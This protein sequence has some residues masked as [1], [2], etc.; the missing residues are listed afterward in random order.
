[1]VIETGA[2]LR[3]RNVSMGSLLFGVKK[4]EKKKEGFWTRTQDAKA[5]IETPPS[6]FLPRLEVLLF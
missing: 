3:K 5:E 1:M 4:K 6:H 2:R